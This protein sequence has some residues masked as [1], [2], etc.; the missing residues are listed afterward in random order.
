MTWYK[1]ERT[2]DT[3]G[4]K[5]GWG[6]SMISIVNLKGANTSVFCSNPWRNFLHSQQKQDN[7]TVNYSLNFQFGIKIGIKS[8]TSSQDRFEIVYFCAFFSLKK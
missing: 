7:G 8:T 1:A 5:G 3:G 6:D 2:R 4:E